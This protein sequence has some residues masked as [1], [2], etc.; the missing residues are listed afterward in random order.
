[1][2]LA[3]GFPESATE[4]RTAAGIVWTIL[5]IFVFIRIRNRFLR[6]A[7]RSVARDAEKEVLRDSSRRPILYLRSFQLDERIGRPTWPER[8]FGSPPMANLEQTLTQVLRKHGP[9]IAIGR[10]DESLPP[11]GAARFYVSHDRWQ[12]KVVDVTSVCRYVVWATGV[13]EGLRW[14][15][16]HLLEN[17]PAEK[18]I[19][20]A[21]PHL[22]RA[23]G[24]QREAEWA[25][26]RAALGGLFP[27]SLPETLGDA[28]FIYFTPDWQPRPVAPPR[29]LLSLPRSIVNPQGAALRAAL[30]VKDGK[31]AESAVAYSAAADR[32]VPRSF[33]ELIGAT[34]AGFHW[35]RLL[36]FLAA[37]VAYQ[38]PTLW[39][40][41][42]RFFT[43]GLWSALLLFAAAAIA[44]RF[45]PDAFGAAATAALTIAIVKAT[46]GEGVFLRALHP[47]ASTF[48]LLLGL[49][50]A[51]RRIPRLVLA[52][53]AGAIGAWAVDWL[54]GY[55]ISPP[56]GPWQ[57]GPVLRD[58]LRP[59]LFALVLLLGV[60]KAPAPWGAQL[61]N[62]PN[63]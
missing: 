13:T 52:L 53:S 62:A 47:F 10:P 30:A 58:L 60:R 33:G 44:F 45:I 17:L 54:L 21:H 1:V 56:D 50:I 59:A 7:W 25:R 51:L 5:V 36:V 3:A 4:A 34:G 55:W 63:R 31:K 6:N 42:G 49:D 18:V 27:H 24:A 43:S 28:R 16:S 35:P 14:E 32:D 46:P 12:Q 37:C 29:A 9:V 20:W 22:L 8:F 38:L 41:A 2:I 23:D 19:L 57:I 26:F 61:P 40:D 15:I 39:N 11:L 48:V